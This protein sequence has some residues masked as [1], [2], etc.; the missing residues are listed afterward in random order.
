MTFFT[1]HPLDVAPEP[2]ATLPSLDPAI[3]IAAGLV[4]LAVV[5]FAVIA[6]QKRRKK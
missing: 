5:V 1:L 6:I 4:I 2:E 3:V